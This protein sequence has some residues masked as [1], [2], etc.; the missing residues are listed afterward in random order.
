MLHIFL[1]RRLTKELMN[2][3]LQTWLV[4]FWATSQ[5]VIVVQVVQCSAWHTSA[6]TC[7]CK[8][9]WYCPVSTCHLAWWPPLLLSR[10]Q[11]NSHPFDESF[12]FYRLN[13]AHPKVSDKSTPKRPAAFHSDAGDFRPRS[14][15]CPILYRVLRWTFETTS[16]LKAW[17]VTAFH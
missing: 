8:S 1:G 14:S 11:S 16:S 15:V 12:C 13:L 2:V 17:C 6:I 9:S 5:A 4:L 3:P 10:C 7:F